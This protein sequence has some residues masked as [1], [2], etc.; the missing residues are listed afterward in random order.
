MASWLHKAG[1]CPGDRV[2][3]AMRNRP[4]WGVAFVATALLGAIP[5]PLNSFGL[6]E[7]LHAA[8]ADLAPKV[9]F[10][11]PERHARIAG[12]G[13]PD[14]FH[15]LGAHRHGIEHVALDHLEPRMT[16][17]AALGKGVAMTVVEDHHVV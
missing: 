4:E 9:V 2:A 11:D 15:D 6:R 14:Q 7:E 12:D 1:V 10:C 13:A 17:E 3:I 5:A 16:D 8:L